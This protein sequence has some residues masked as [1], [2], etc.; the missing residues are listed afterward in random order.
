MTKEWCVLNDVPLPPSP[1][2]CSGAEKGRVK[3]NDCRRTRRTT[4]NWFRCAGR[5]IPRAALRGSSRERT[6][7]MGLGSRE[8]GK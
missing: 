6:S 8:V 4:I 3:S 7:L 1:T 5:M 2:P